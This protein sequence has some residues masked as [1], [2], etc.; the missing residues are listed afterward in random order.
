[1]AASAGR[2]RIEGEVG[3]KAP[4]CPEDVAGAADEPAG[5]QPAGN[6]RPGDAI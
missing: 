6:P 1:M 5:L 2:D 3:K 4:D